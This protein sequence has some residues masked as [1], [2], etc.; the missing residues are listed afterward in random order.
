MN[1]ERKHLK[2]Q[3]VDIIEKKGICIKNIKNKTYSQLKSEYDNYI[4]NMVIESG[5]RKENIELSKDIVNK[6]WL[7][8]LE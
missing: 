4:N 2:K 6:L 5:N 1:D 8:I 7:E 3:L